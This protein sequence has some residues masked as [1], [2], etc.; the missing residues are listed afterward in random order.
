M[1]FNCI[2]LSLFIILYLFSLRATSLINSSASSASAS[3]VTAKTDNV[4]V[5]P[6]TTIDSANHS[7][8]GLCAMHSLIMFYHAPK[9]TGLM[10][11]TSTLKQL[12]HVHNVHTTM[13]SKVTTSLTSVTTYTFLK[14]GITLQKIQLKMAGARLSPHNN[15]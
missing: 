10:F 1:F 2:H 14:F 13:Q 9:I 12:N 7:K 15:K 6:A 4:S 3:H 8:S 11:T 5:I